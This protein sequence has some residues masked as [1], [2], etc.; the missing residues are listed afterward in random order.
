MLDAAK[1]KLRVKIS[2]VMIA[3]TVAGCILMVIE[4]KQVRV[5]FL[6]LFVSHKGPI[7]NQGLTPIFILLRRKKAAFTQEII[8]N[9]DIIGPNLGSC[10]GINSK[11]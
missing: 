7:G 11:S 5:D 4:G 2:Y 1:N 6:S 9:K 10:R 3:L 8:R